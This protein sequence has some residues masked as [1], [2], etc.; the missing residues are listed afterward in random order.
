MASIKGQ[1]LH[2]YQR[3]DFEKNLKLWVNRNI[4]DEILYDI[5]N[6]KIW[7]NFLNNGTVYDENEILN[8]QIKFFNKEHADDHLDIIINVN[9][10]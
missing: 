9:W 6:G 4:K 1:L 7:K 2:M 5:Y 3:Q 8:K 10:F